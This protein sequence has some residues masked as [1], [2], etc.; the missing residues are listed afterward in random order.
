[1]ERIHQIS[2]AAAIG[3]FGFILGAAPDYGSHLEQGLLLIAWC[4]TVGGGIIRAYTEPP[5]ET[6]GNRL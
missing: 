2:T 5:E 3:G 6:R 4:C 1:M